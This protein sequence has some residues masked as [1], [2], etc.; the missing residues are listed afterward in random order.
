MLQ[1]VN[2]E[3]LNL[4]LVDAEEKLTAWGVYR[5]KKL[6]TPRKLIEEIDEAPSEPP[7]C[8]KEP[9]SVRLKTP[10]DLSCIKLVSAM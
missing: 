9:I 2:L 10:N 1:H 5:L 3:A 4:R 7:P 6:H 8:P